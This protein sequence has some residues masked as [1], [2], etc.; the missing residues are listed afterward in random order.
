MFEPPSRE[1]TI[2]GGDV[3]GQDFSASISN[4]DGLVAYYPF[5]GNANDESGNGHDGTVLGTTLTSDRFGT[6]NS[7]YNFN[8]ND[9]RIDLGNP[10]DFESPLSFSGWFRLDAAAE[11]QWNTLFMK[12]QYC[13]GFGVMYNANTDQSGRKFFRIYNSSCEGIAGTDVDYMVTY[14][15]WVHYTLVYDGVSL[16]TYING[17]LVGTHAYSS[18]ILDEDQMWLGANGPDDRV[19]G[20]YHFTGDID[21][22]RIYDR[23]LTSDEVLA[24]CEEGG[25]ECG[26]ST[27]D[28]LV[29]YYPFNG[30]AN[31]ESGNGH[32]GTVNGATLTS[33]RFGRDDVAYSFDGNND[34]IEVPS[35]PGFT[36]SEISISAWIWLDR[37][38]GN[39]Q[40][41]IVNRQ[42][43]SGG[44]EAWGLEI[45]GNN[46]ASSGPGNKLA[47][48][49]NTGTDAA[50]TISPTLLETG[51]WYHVVGTSDGI[52]ARLY[53][54]GVLDI[55]AP[56]PG[57]LDP[58]NNADIVIGKTG[59]QSNFYFPGIIDDI[60]IY[61]RAL[62]ETEVA[63]LC[64]EGGWQGCGD[65]G[66]STYTLSGTVTD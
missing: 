65:A 57:S 47:F 23:A 26:G 56:A 60:R 32:D 16:E 2:S 25:W 10:V 48:H 12:S 13:S 36:M 14:A 1:V 34:Y 30:N 11:S 66:I 4:A 54:N 51:R 15:D 3:T 38:I 46:Y 52:E 62:S 22:V 9:S 59:P 42:S 37:D 44:L 43:T 49:A 19:N 18:S 40:A 64:E 35:D 28:G 41:R 5:N 33:D 6:P 17:N 8:G 50:N 20:Y 24:L 21:D 29:A 55:T 31:D 53:I 45:F 27:L 61:N 58:N 63:E 39:E 7:A